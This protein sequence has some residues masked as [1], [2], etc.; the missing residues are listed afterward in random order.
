VESANRHVVGVRVKPAGMRWT[1]EG[2]AGVLALRALLRSA[3]WDQWGLAQP[4][5]IPLAA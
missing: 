5:P 4:P 1:A 2:M 3:R